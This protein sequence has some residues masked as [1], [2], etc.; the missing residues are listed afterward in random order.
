MNSR[1]S[2]NGD[3]SFT[4]TTGGNTDNCDFYKQ[5]TN[6]FAYSVTGGGSPTAPTHSCNRLGT[7]ATTAL[8]TTLS[9]I[10]CD[11]SS[12]ATSTNPLG[13]STS[14]ERWVSTDASESI[15]A[16]GASVTF[17]Y[18]RQYLVTNPNALSVTRTN[19]GTS[20]TITGNGF[21]DTDTSISVAATYTQS[22][23]MDGARWIYDVTAASIGIQL[24]CDQACSAITY[25][26]NNP[27]APFLSFT[28]ASSGT[29]RIFIPSAAGLTITQVTNAGVANTAYAFSSNVITETGS[30]PHEVDFSTSSTGGGAPPPTDDSAP[31]PTGGGGGI[32]II[33]TTATNSTSGI[34]PLAT[35]GNVANIIPLSLLIAAV[36][37]GVAFYSYGI[38]KT[39]EKAI[40]DAERAASRWWRSLGILGERSRSRPIKLRG[41]RSRRIK[42]KENRYS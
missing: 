30:S 1:W 40:A 20:A 37:G 29:E 9:G 6:S 8:T 18:Q 38:K 33:T 24:L 11:H 5:W 12:T 4:Q 34:A 26:T 31:P 14:T 32:L 27:A 41:E 25:N 35:Q 17:A 42:L 28:T 21:V 15:T 19:N 10:Y 3:C 39:P 2:R 7:A 22:W 13:T 36:F 16:G 23:T